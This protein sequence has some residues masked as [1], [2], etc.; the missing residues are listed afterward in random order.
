MIFHRLLLSATTIILL[1][2]GSTSADDA[3]LFVAGMEIRLGMAKEEVFSRLGSGYSFSEAGK[4]WYYIKETMGSKTR[5][6]GG[7]NL[8]DNKVSSISKWWGTF[9]AKDALDCAIELHSALRNFQ[10]VSGNQVIVHASETRSTP[11]LRISEIEF[12]SGSR[13]LTVSIL[14]GDKSSGQRQVS[15]QETLSVK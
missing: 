15:I 6:I 3:T 10:E 4:N 8:Q 7:I 12:L 2:A 1:F 14:E 5:L 9:Y 13:K 11:G